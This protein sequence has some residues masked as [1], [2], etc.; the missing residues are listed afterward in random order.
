MAT[1]AT[2]HQVLS[3]EQWERIELLLPS[4]EGRKGHPFRDNRRIVE[5]IVYRSRTGIPWRDLPRDQ[6]GPW[7]TVW[8]RHFLYA[9]LGGWDRVHAALMA[10][11][12]AAGDIDW[13]VSV[14]STING[15]R[16]HGTH[17]TR[18]DQP[19]GGGSEPQ[20]SHR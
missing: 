15:A 4:N 14:D 20:E 9:R 12:D 1:A 2:R 11:A 19:A 17:T 6:F 18:P 16:R 13:T 7:K 3:D 8:K 5:G 10:Q